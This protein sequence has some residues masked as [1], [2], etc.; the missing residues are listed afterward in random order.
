MALKSIGANPLRHK[1]IRH[2]DILTV[3]GK[4]GEGGPSIANYESGCL[5]R[6][7]NARRR[8]TRRRLWWVN[9]L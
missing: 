1:R 4:K 3:V 7:R 8:A 5:R 2:S 6:L 9:E